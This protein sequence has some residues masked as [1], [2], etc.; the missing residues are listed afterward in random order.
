MINK[1]KKILLPSLLTMFLALSI[2]SEVKSNNI[3]VAQ[4]IPELHMVILQGNVY[5]NGSL[6][7][8]L[9]G[10][11][12]E[13]RVDNFVLGTVEIGE[14]TT[15]R[16]SGFGIGPAS[17]YE[18]KSISFYVGNEKAAETTVF[19]PVSPSGGYCS[20][21]T[22]S[23]P[24]SRTVD[25]SF[26]KFPEPTPTPVP[27]LV[28]P[29]FV[30]GNLIFGSSLI[31][32][33]QLTTIEAIINGEVVG[34]GEVI[35]SKF[36]ITIDPGNE[37]FVSMPVTFRMGSYM[38]KTTYLFSP[39]DFITDFKLFFPEYIPPT[40]TISVPTSTPIPL[41]TSTPEPTRTP[42]PVPLPTA[43]YTAT[44]TPTPIVLSTTSDSSGSQI[45]LEDSDTGGCNSRGG[46][47]ASLSLIV[48]S[49]APLYLLNRRRRKS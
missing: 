9:D 5:I 14:S 43:T 49:A 17:E 46:G 39:D 11:L 15:G 37:L 4:D 8:N 16:Y 34:I 30:T 7:S 3:L 45:I 10:Y 33:Q 21:C 12:L 36:S 6:A 29:A 40:P 25:I 20:G 24:I 44:P 26:T 42:T 48:L 32:P 47:A 23:L 19:G 28:S 2:F 18:G 22:W 35:D 27:A 31:A 13:A 38:S 41:P 1:I